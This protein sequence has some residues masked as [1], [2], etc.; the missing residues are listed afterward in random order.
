MPCVNATPEVAGRR[1]TG[2]ARNTIIFSIA[3]D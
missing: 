1:R 3:T 2:V